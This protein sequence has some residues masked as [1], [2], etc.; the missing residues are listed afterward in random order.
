MAGHL[1]K[2]ARST[3]STVSPSCSMMTSR[4][5]LPLMSFVW[6]IS[7][8]V[9]VVIAADEP[10]LHQDAKSLAWIWDGGSGAKGD[11]VV[12]ERGFKLSKAPSA[13]R[14]K[15]QS[16]APVKLLVNGEEVGAVQS[17]D[18]PQV[19]EFKKQ[20]SVGYNAL[21]LVTN[22]AG[23]GDALVAS[24]LIT[25]ADGTRRRL[26][27]DA[28]WQVVVG[29]ERRAV[30]V[31]ESYAASKKGDVFAPL[32]PSVTKTEDIKVPEGFKVDL[33][34]ALDEAEGS[35]VAMCTD[36]K[37]R[38]IASDAGGRLVRITPPPVGADVSKNPPK[39]EVIDLPVGHAN[40][41]LWA[42]DSLYVMVC[43]EGVYEAGSGV[44]RVRDT[45]GDDRFD[46]VELL[47]KL[48]GSGDHGP[49]ALMLSPD[50]RS[51]TVV[52]GNST[53][54][55]EFQHYQVPP[56]YKD[57]LALP[58]LKGH[59]FMLGVG[60]PAGY[61]ARMSPD[62]Q[63]WTLIASGLRNQYDAA[64]NRHG[65][66]FTYDADMEWD[67]GT[68]W[69]RPTRVCHVVDGAE[70][71]WRSVSGKWAED[72]AD[73]VPPVIN[74][75]RGSPTGVAFGYG[76]K[77]PGRYQE[78]L[79]IA[80]WTYGRLY[81]VHLKERGASYTATQEVFVEGRA[82][83]PTDIAVNEK[84]GALYFASG[85]RTGN[86]ALYR[87]YYAG[88]ESTVA[89]QGSSDSESAKLRALRHRLEEA[90]QA[91]DDASVQLALENLGHS[92]RFIRY[93]ARTLLEFRAPE[94]WEKA[95]LALKGPD[96]G[97]QSALALARLERT[98]H[99][100]VLYGKL[101]EILGGR[102]AG[103]GLKLDAVR[104]LQVVAVRLGDPEGTVRDSLL[105]HLHALVPTTDARMNAEAG[106]LLVRWKS[107]LAAR[108]LFALLQKAPTQ[109]EQISYAAALRFVKE[110]WPAGAR[111]LFFR[112]FL[113]AE[114]NKAG[115]LAKF[116]AD[117]RK[118]AVDSL[119]DAEKVALE[120]VLNAAPE[121]QPAPPMA[122]RLFVKNWTTEELSGLVEPLMKEARNL[123]RG[124]QLFRETGCTVCHL[125]KSEGGAV[126]PDLTLS[127]SKFGVRELIESMTEPSKTISDQYGTTQ[128]TLKS[129]ETFIGRKVN[130]GPELVTLQ[131]NVFTASDVRDFARKDISKVEASLVSLMPPGLINTCHPDE[132]ADLL[133]WLQ[134]GSK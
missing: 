22:R 82:M 90:Y 97:V 53:R 79:Y 46:K 104:A 78:A 15:I 101:G 83:K 49:H 114:F 77:F 92:D 96:A 116:I 106:Q 19:F 14:V 112:W 47:R 18:K 111:E 131:E 50:K 75:G 133:A 59:G 122:S 41:L 117:M 125:F 127:G 89:S 80:D 100:D 6:L 44:Y 2:E 32:R 71:G 94:R 69:Y 65:E 20:V 34:H 62:G 115:H 129:G 118:D 85:S 91:S 31:V 64:F 21:R 105:G 58:K 76:A 42:F 36:G 40:G 99:R 95:A 45:D 23:E 107:P 60:A 63:E 24:V 33:L 56:I 87:V 54:A 93:A 51:I 52:C 12:F 123:E 66:L 37:G 38:L 98:E 17:A 13:V 29:D 48:H 16:S 26:E 11:A 27:T 119:S 134:S 120:K 9:S 3:H 113:R 132:V 55:T 109:E 72:Y 108:K 124:K 130:E 5:L 35:W 74:V 10:P 81:A 70:F 4:S 7:Q 28:A 126:G 8:P 67:L 110:G 73:S 84:D 1:L 61:L 88:G 121:V 30:R 43:A 102:A 68:P 103:A 25:D 39:I 128:V 86:S 57:D